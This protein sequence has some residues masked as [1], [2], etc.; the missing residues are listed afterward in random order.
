MSPGNVT[1]QAFMA[2]SSHWVWA[3]GELHAAPVTLG[4]LGDSQQ[5]G[6]GWSGIRNSAGD[7]PAGGRWPAGPAP[8]LF[9]SESQLSPSPLLGTLVMHWFRG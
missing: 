5:D 2:D 9:L 7:P 6:S 1:S 8:Q 4:H 3:I